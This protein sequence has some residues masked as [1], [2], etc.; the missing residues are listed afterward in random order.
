DY[1]WRRRPRRQLLGGIPPQCRGW[2]VHNLDR[3]GR[4]EKPECDPGAG[5]EAHPWCEPS[6]YH[7]RLHEQALLRVVDISEE[8]SP[9][10]SS[11]RPE[12]PGLAP[13]CS[14]SA[15]ASST[16]HRLSSASGRFRVCQS[17]RRSLRHSLASSINWWSPTTRPA[18]TSATA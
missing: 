4:V 18:S 5:G 2:A 8:S 10:S 7:R 11:G 1:V 3:T 12:V 17:A 6:I 13:P 15:T 14:L 16:Y 9:Q